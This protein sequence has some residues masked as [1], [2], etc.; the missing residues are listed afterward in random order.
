MTVTLLG[1]AP[2]RLVEILGGRIL[3]REHSGPAVAAMVVEGSRRGAVR[4]GGPRPSEHEPGRPSGPNP[5]SD[6]GGGGPIGHS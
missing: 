4:A 2:L 6:R 1:H 3:R 5:L